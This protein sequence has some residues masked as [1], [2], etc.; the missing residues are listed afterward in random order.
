MANPTNPPASA[1]E[2]PLEYQLKIQTLSREIENVNDIKALKT[3][4]VRI[5]E[6][7]IITQYL[8]CEALRNKISL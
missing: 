6:N 4:T 8:Y 7:A 3:M 2:L 5:L 1:P